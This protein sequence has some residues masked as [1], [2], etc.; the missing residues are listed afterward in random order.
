MFGVGISQRA[1]D[2]VAGGLDRIRRET[3]IEML[4]QEV[5]AVRNKA[6]RDLSDYLTNFERMRREYF[7]IDCQPENDARFPLTMEDCLREE[8]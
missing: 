7:F 6:V 1:D 5:V 4:P 8:L 2:I 3:G